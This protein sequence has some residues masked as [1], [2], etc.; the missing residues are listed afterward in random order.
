M[1]TAPDPEHRAS[2][3][4]PGP[5]TYAYA[6]GRP[7]VNVDPDGRKIVCTTPRTQQELASLKA[8]PHVGS[9]VRWLDDRCGDSYVYE[10]AV[11]TPSLTA[12]AGGS[13]QINR[14]PL[15]DI[16]VTTVVALTA[17]DR[18]TMARWELPT[19]M[20]HLLAHELA[21]AF[22]ALA[23]PRATADQQLSFAVSV[24]NIA[25]APGPYR[26]AH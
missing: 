1:Y 13:T 7:L 17:A 4:M 26:G 8:D 19:T 15:G 22:L 9:I 21:H 14:T 5:Q 18:A 3:M 6:G 16:S 2:V 10:A 20:R 12:Q 25:R 24:E 23:D 11:S